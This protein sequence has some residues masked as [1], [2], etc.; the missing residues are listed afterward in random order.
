MNNHNVIDG[1]KNKSHKCIPNKNIPRKWSQLSYSG[2]ERVPEPEDPK[3]G[4]WA[5][6]FLNRDK[7]GNF[8]DSNGEII[9]FRIQQ[10]DF[11]IDFEGEVIHYRHTKNGRPHTVPLARPLASVLKQYIKVRT[12]GSENIE[13]LSLLC[14]VYGESITPSNL[15]KYVQVYN[16]ERGVEMCSLHGFRRFYVKSLVCQGVPIPKIMH[17]VQH[18]TVSMVA[19]YSKIYA[20]DLVNDVDIFASNISREETNK[21]RI[22]K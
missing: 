8:I 15:Y 5:T 1:I 22:L 19:H 16:R 12:Q 21:K 17:L 14:N 13:E 10:P 20:N 18:S 11:N 3:S 7:Y 4:S 9:A 6:F 2:E